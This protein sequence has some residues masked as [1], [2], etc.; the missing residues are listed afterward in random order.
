[1]N[2]WQREEG[3][4]DPPGVTWIPA[5]NAYNFVLYARHATRVEM[6]EALEG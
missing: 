1:M 6:I 4:I 5:E 2:S 3:W